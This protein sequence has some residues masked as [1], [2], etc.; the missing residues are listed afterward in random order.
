MP[1]TDR[2]NDFIQV[3]HEKQRD[4][5]EAK[6]RKLTHPKSPSPSQESSQVASGKEYI[7]EAYTV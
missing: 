2:T 4:I 5:P 3:L 7:N 6:K 1:F